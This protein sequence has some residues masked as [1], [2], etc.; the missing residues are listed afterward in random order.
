MSDEELEDIPPGEILFCFANNL[1]AC[2]ADCMAYH[3]DPPPNND[4]QGMQTHCI[5]ISSVARAGRSLNILAS[6]SNQQMK[7]AMNRPVPNPT[8]G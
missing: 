7:N 4:L 8:G 5:L 1:R 3:S 2:G 6:I